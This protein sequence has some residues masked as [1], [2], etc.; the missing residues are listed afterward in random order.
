MKSIIMFLILIFVI[1]GCS[2]DGP[3]AKV[4]LK[5]QDQANFTAYTTRIP[6]SDYES[7]AVALTNIVYP[8]TRV[9]NAAGAIILCQPDPYVAFTAM[10]RITHMPVNAPLLYI[11]KNGKIS[12]QTFKEMKRIMPDGVLQ[13]GNIQVYIVGYIDDSEITKIKKLLKYKIRHFNEI[14]P[15]KLA[16]QLD[17]WQAALKSDHPDEVVISA[18]DH[19]DGIAHGIGPMGWNAHMGRGFAWVYKDSVPEAT[20]K[21]LERRLSDEGNYIYLTGG[22]EI[23]SDKVAKELSKYGLVRRIFGENVYESSTVNAGYKDYGRNFGWWWSWEPRAFGWGISQAGHNF[24]IGT[25]E[26]ILSVIPAVVLGHMGKHGPVL[27]VDKDSIPQPVINYLK[28]VKSFPTGP[29]ETILN[30]A[31]IIGDSTKISTKAQM[32]IDKYLSPF[33]TEQIADTL[34]IAEV[35]N[36]H[37]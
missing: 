22:S 5:F 34:K 3:P 1:A 21:I 26:N 15:I 2:T 10:H 7:Q 18:Y 27:L 4:D 32:E 8:S 20:R 24:I 35:K 6:A 30:F 13:D 36:G 12:D 33:P 29:A 25:P 9:D 23:I 19:P 28:M 16:E 17:R 31:W 11:S 37:K 14:D